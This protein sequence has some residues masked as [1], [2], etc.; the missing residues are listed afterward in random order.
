MR[1]AYKLKAKSMQCIPVFET[2]CDRI[3]HLK[4]SHYDIHSVL[5]SDRNIKTQLQQLFSSGCYYRKINHHISVHLNP[6]S[7]SNARHNA[8]NEAFMKQMVNTI[9]DEMM[10]RNQT[11]SLI[12]HG[13]TSSGK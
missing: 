4:R 13:D 5:S 12:F 3:Q 9:R 6:Y 7:L 8:Y 2:K 11:Q 1:K 10:T